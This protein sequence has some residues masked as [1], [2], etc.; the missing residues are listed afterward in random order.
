MDN[1]NKMFKKTGT[2]IEE[3]TQKIKNNESIIELL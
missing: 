1:H 2:I 3:L